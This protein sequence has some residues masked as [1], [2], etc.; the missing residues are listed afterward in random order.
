LVAATLGLLA[1]G[2][3]GSALVLGFIVIKF[4]AIGVA[5]V[6]FISAPLFIASTIAAI[7]EGKSNITTPDLLALA[8]LTVLIQG[9]FWLVLII[10]VVSGGL[11]M[12]GAPGGF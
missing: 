8:W 4:W 5:V 3:L 11:S 9:G 7:W 1:V 12:G 6:V 2:S 10:W